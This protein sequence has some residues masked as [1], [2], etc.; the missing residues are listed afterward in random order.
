LSCPCAFK[1]KRSRK[2]NITMFVSLFIDFYK[3]YNKGKE[4]GGSLL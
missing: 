2:K 4:K 1:A 3:D